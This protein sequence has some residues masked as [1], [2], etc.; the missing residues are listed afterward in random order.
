MLHRERP[1]SLRRSEHISFPQD[2]VHHNKLFHRPN[3]QHHPIVCLS[4][5]RIGNPR[6]VPAVL[7]RHL[8]LANHRRG[9]R[10]T[11]R[12]GLQVPDIDR[13]QEGSGGRIRYR[14]NSLYPLPGTGPL[15]FA[16]RGKTLCEGIVPSIQSMASEGGACW[17]SLT[18]IRYF[19]NLPY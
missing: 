13:T 11:G 6:T 9:L 8:Q 2:K 15:A 7:T 10:V 17:I 5:Q 12:P 4:P 3:Y 16:I 14:K 18:G 1:S 19:V